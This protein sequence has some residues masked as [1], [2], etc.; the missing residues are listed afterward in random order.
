MYYQYNATR[1]V[2]QD[3]KIAAT[4]SILLTS[5]WCTDGLFGWFQIWSEVTD[6]K[7]QSG[8]ITSK[9]TKKISNELLNVVNIASL[10]C[11]H[12]FTER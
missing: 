7:F 3:P 6:A 11:L 1:R 9:E 2:A 12:D 8:I 4:C 10:D 5:L